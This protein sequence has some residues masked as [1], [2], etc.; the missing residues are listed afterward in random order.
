MFPY[1]PLPHVSDF[2][3]SSEPRGVPERGFP[4]CRFD[5]LHFYV[6]K[7]LQPLQAYKA[8]EAQLNTFAAGKDHGVDPRRAWAELT[9]EE[10]AEYSPQARGRAAESLAAPSIL[11]STISVPVQ[12]RRRP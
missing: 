8:L 9:Q 12:Y 4:A 5:H 2:A 1:A 7:P 10:P 11:A 6:D 3:G